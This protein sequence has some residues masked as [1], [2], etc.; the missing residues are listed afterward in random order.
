MLYFYLYETNRRCV[1]CPSETRAPDWLQPDEPSF[2]SELD[3]S[4]SNIYNF[5]LAP[6]KR[7]PST[8]SLNI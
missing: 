6:Q 2:L 5:R 8:V 7:R 3:A 4:L 1:Q